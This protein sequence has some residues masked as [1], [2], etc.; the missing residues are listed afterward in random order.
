[1]TSV[2]CTHNALDTVFLYRAMF[3]G[4]CPFGCLGERES[5][6]DAVSDRSLYNSMLWLLHII[7]QLWSYSTKR[8]DS[9]RTPP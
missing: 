2:N 6:D 7:R 8:T 4:A 3:N 1:V 5:D 9:P